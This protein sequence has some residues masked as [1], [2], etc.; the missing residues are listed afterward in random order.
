MKTRLPV[1][2]AFLSGLLM[3]VAFFGTGDAL[4]DFSNEALRYMSIVAGFAILLG[5]I[6]IT[7]VSLGVV[8]K[9]EKEW[10][11]KI[12]LLLCLFTMTGFGIFQGITSGTV[13]EWLFEN[14]QKPMMATMFSILAFF[15][16][17]AAYR[18]FRARTVEATILLITAI[19]VM[20][21]RVP[22]GQYLY[23]DFPAV[24]NWIMMF[25]SV[26][27]QRGIIIGAALGA[28]SMSLRIILGIER[29]YMGR[30]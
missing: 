19:V 17:S 12:V 30:G 26:A 10:P 1:A 11:Y 8:R 3:I 20:L 22:M 21:G 28:A 29:T 9:R 7:R 25:P 23:E 27:V 2:I 18:A 6:S 13:F 14:I 16:A 24:A 4:A 5:A 15:I